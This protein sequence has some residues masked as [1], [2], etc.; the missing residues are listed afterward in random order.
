[1]DMKKHMLFCFLISMLVD[2]IKEWGSYKMEVVIKKG[3]REVV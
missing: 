1:M 2:R 3:G